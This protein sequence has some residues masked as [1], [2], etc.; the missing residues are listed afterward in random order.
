MLNEWLKL[1]ERVAVALERM[2]DAAEADV[3][4][5]DSRGDHYSHLWG[6][7]TNDLRQEWKRR[8][9]LGYPGTEREVRYVP[10]GANKPMEVVN[11]SQRDG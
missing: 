11:G 10:A 7:S 2:A 4:L 6:I 9:E 3:A 5:L 1:A 8:S